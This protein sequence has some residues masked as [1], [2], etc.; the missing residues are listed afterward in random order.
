MGASP[1]EKGITTMREFAAGALSV[2][3]NTFPPPLSPLLLA[4]NS[5]FVNLSIRYNPYR[6]IPGRLTNTSC[7]R[8]R[9]IVV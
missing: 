2:P 3:R 8:F 5:L 1:V 4:P 6:N 9:C 7:E